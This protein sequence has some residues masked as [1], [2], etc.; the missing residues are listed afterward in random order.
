MFYDDVSSVQHAAPFQ[1]KGRVISQVQSRQSLKPH[2]AAAPMPEEDMNGVSA[3][4]MCFS[5]K[6][7]EIMKEAL[8]ATSKEDLV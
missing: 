4:G 8:E 6:E 1:N 7:I 2:K 3:L 5:Q